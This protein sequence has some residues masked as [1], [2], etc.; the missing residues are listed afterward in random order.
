MKIFN[1]RQ[2]NKHNIR[3]GLLDQEQRVEQKAKNKMPSEL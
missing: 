2:F 3:S 1:L